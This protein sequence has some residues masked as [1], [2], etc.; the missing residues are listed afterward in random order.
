MILV[1]LKGNRREKIQWNLWI[2]GTY[3]SQKICPL[4]RDVCYWE[5]ILKRLPHFE[6]YVLSA[7]PGM[8]AVWDIRYWEVS[9]Y[10]NISTVIDILFSV[11]VS[12]N[13]RLFSSWSCTYN[14]SNLC[15]SSS[16]SFL[17]SWKWNK[18]CKVFN[19]IAISVELGFTKGYIII[20]INV[21]VSGPFPMSLKAWHFLPKLLTLSFHFNEAMLLLERCWCN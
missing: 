20:F 3:G 2:E 8:S 19:T 17:T 13:A 5:V 1:S 21:F 15:K 18:S 9:L 16:T 4:L 6:L 14:D 7:I 11:K 10:I 12:Q